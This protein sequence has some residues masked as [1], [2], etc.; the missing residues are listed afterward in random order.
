MSLHLESVDHELNKSGVGIS[1]DR[2]KE[3]DSNVQIGQQVTDI[4]QLLMKLLLNC[5]LVR[6]TILTTHND[7]CS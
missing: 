6:Q 4:Q 7:N 5:C 3:T 1:T 2:H